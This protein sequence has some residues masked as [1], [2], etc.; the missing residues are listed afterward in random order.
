MNPALRTYVQDRL[1]GTI[2]SCSGVRIEGPEV[3]WKA[4]RAVHRQSRRWS[5]AWSPEQ[6]ARRLR[7]DFP[8]DPTMHISHEAIY[9]ALYIQGRGALRRELSA[10]LRSGRVL[11]MP[12]E[13]ALNRGK[14]YR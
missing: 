9:Q 7:L 13:R 14:F 6:I 3:Q 11:R 1:A 4:R 12:R 5:A 2:T 8:Q 10:Y